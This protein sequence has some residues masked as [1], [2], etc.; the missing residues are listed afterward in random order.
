MKHKHHDL[1][2]KW[3]EDISQEVEVSVR[4]R[5]WRPCPNPT[6]DNDLQYQFK[7]AIKQAYVKMHFTRKS[8]PEDFAAYFT[9]DCGKSEKNNPTHV[10]TYEGDKIISI[11]EIK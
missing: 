10:I 8:G 7:P 2:V 6:W 4:G 1:I 5:H 3:L 11:S 9:S